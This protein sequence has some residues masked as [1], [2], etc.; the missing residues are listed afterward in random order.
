M[1]DLETR[2]ERLL[3]PGLGFTVE[4][5]VY[6]PGELGVRSEVNVVVGEGGARVT[7]EPQR[8]LILLR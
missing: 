5:G 3:V 1:D 7:T 8:Q 4:P 6:L 2:D